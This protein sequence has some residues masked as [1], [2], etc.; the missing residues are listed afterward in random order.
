MKNVLI[1]L[2]TILVVGGSTLSAAD[3]PTFKAVTIDEHA[4]EI[5]YAV[6]LA[7]VNGDKQPDVVAVTED[8]V[9]WYENPS[10]QKHVIVKNQTQKDNVCIAPQD[11]DGDG[12]IDFALGAGWLNGKNT[13]TIQWLTRGESL[14]QPWSVHYIG[15]I[16]WTHRMRWADVLGKGQPQLVVSPLKKTKGDGVALTAFEI[17]ADPKKDRWDATVLDSTLNNVHN[18]WHVS[19]ASIGGPADYPDATITASEEGVTAINKKPSGEWRFSKMPQSE[20]AGE[21]KLG[22]LKQSNRLFTVTIEPMHGNKVVV[23]DVVKGGE[24]NRYVIEENLKRGHALWCADL[25]GDGND[26]IIVGH[27]DKGTGEVKGPGVYV[28]KATKDDGSA[29]EKHIIDDGGIATEDAV[30]GDLNGDGK[31]DIIAGGRATHNVKI[32]LNQ[33]N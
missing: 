29:W 21:V 3:F 22:T 31:I 12:K 20:T 17:P 25:T 8:A 13:G 16:P 24:I 18:H 2:T 15:E 32:Y 9:Y 23:Y 4:G 10:W 1:L 11:I 30:A 7:D 33:G 26:E 6:T 14:E 28:Y 5:V 19:P 27:S